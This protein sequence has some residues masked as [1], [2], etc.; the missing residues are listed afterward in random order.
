MKLQDL[1][2]KLPKHKFNA[3]LITRNNRFLGQDILPE[4][5]KI[6]ELTGFTGSAGTLLVTPVTFL[7]KNAIHQIC[8]HD[9]LQ[10]KLYSLHLAAN[11]LICDNTSFL[12]NGMNSSQFNLVFACLSEDQFFRITDQTRTIRRH[13]KN[14]QRFRVY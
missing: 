8:T 10:M 11:S 3:L 1:Q 12:Q 14:H 2:K 6:M 5:N 13:R 7:I 4:E 9:L